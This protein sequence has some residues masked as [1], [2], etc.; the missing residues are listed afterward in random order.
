MPII[1]SAKKRVRLTKKATARNARTS[2]NLKQSLKAFAESI[3]NG[4]ATNI[5]KAKKEAQKAIDIAAKK[6]LIH[7]NKAARTKSKL[8]RDAKAAGAKVSPKKA[9]AKKPTTAKKPVAKTKTSKTPVKKTASS[10]K[11]AK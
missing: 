1:K 4:N 7:K 9:A 8:D 2:K 6:N 10:K 3:K 11:T 5:G